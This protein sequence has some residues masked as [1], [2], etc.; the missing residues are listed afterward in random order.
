MPGIYIPGWLPSL[1]S[2]YIPRL[3]RRTGEGGQQPVEA[4]GEQHVAQGEGVAGSCVFGSERTEA[5]PVLTATGSG[6]ARSWQGWVKCTAP[7]QVVLLQQGGSLREIS[8][9]AGL[10]IPGLLR[11]NPQIVDANKVRCTVMVSVCSVDASV[12]TR[13]AAPAV[14]LAPRASDRNALPPAR[15]AAPPPAWLCMCLACVRVSCL[16]RLMVC[17]SSWHPCVCR[18]AHRFPAVN[19]CMHDRRPYLR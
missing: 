11:L 7:A 6:G 2:I 10:D 5:S 17:R 4:G 16:Q 9:A 3:A 14:V 12:R 18:P 19:A 8:A 15:A 13:A 1:A